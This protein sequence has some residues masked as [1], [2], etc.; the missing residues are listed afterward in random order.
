MQQMEDAT[1]NRFI[2]NMMVF[3]VV[4]ELHLVHRIQVFLLRNLL[5]FELK[6][7]QN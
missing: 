4:Q 6:L 5:S 2:N 7:T 3:L 1:G